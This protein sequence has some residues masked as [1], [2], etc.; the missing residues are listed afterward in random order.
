MELF[1][2]TS[3]KGG[4]GKTTSIG[5]LICNKAASSGGLINAGT[6]E[7]STISRRIHIAEFMH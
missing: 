5:E 6:V 4:G 1:H 3:A 2:M 7:H